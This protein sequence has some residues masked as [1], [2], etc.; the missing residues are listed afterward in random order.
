RSAQRNTGTVHWLA[1]QLLGARPFQTV[2][3]QE[4]FRSVPEKA[5]ALFHSL[6]ADYPFASPKQTS[7]LESRF[8]TVRPPDAADRRRTHRGHRSQGAGA[9][10]G[11]RNGSR[12]R[13]EVD[14][15][16]DPSRSD[17][18]RPPRAGSVFL[19][20]SDSLF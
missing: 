10:V 16:I 15:L 12:L 14:D 17:R 2:F 13:R 7:H 5:S 4:I 20:S 19:N 1:R 8:Q 11:G 9:P 6:I 18:T 3:G